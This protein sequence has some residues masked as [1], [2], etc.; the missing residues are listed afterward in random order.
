MI[1]MNGSDEFL[2]AIQLDDF[3]S[4]VEVATADYPRAA[5]ITSNI[6]IYDG[7]E[8]DEG[9]KREWANVIGK[10]PGVF[11][12]R[13]AFR[14]LSAVDAAT[15]IF[16]EIIADERAAGISGG[17]HFAKAGAND[18]IWNSLQKLCLRAP[19]VYVRYMG[20]P[21]VDL[22]CRA[23]LGPDYQLATQVN[24]VRPGGKAQAPHR[25][26][27]L[28]FMT[29]DQMALYPPHIHLMGP[30]LILQGGVAHVD[31]PAASGTTKLLP[32]SQKYPQGYVAAQLPEFRDYFEANCVQLPMAKGDAI[33][34]S[35]ALF[36]AA[37]ENKTTDFVRMVNLLQVASAFAKHMENIDRLAM[38]KAIFPY[39]GSLS[40]QE[41]AGVIAA[42]ADAYP[43]PTNLDTTP[44]VGGLAPESQ[45][46]LLARAIAEGWDYPRFEAAADQQAQRRRA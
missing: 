7:R 20:N 22:A 9:I 39:L 1:V 21:I 27:H 15:E 45:K 36:H 4:Q 23:W 32:H 35:P 8:V 37:G 28:G 31:M 16:R 33:F 26:Y 34:F 2:G 25:D 5:E 13:S 43:F 6:P 10:G 42:T 29:P 41:R 44:P 38:V 40:A 17:D 14:D 11:V 19:E 30:T 18:R 24:Q 46:A 3:R 12:V